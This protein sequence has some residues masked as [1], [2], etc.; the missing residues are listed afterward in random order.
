[1]D[2]R[3]FVLSGV[4]VTYAGYVLDDLTDTG[5]GRLVRNLGAPGGPAV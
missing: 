2:G 1:M 5:L 4:R 3:G